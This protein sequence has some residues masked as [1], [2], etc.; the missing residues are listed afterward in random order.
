M[1]IVIVKMAAGRT[2]DQKEAMA[3]DITDAVVKNLALPNADHV[4]VLC[5][6]LARDD[7]IIAG[8]PLSKS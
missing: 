8:T 5:E 6:E 3:R 1:P 2:Q 7:I 4:W